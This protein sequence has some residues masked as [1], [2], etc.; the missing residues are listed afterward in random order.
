MKDRDGKAKKLFYRYRFFR[1]GGQKTDSFLTTSAE[2]M[3]LGERKEI[4]FMTESLR[5]L[6]CASFSPIHEG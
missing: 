4:G 1:G 6:D 5:I 3:L 2:R